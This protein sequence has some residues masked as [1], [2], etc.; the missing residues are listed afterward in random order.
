LLALMFILAFPAISTAAWIIQSSFSTKMPEPV[1]CRT[2]VF[3][4]G[5]SQGQWNYLEIQ[6]ECERDAC[7]YTLKN[8]LC[9]NLPVLCMHFWYVFFYGL[10]TGNWSSTCILHIPILWSKAT[11]LLYSTHMHAIELLNRPLHL[12]GARPFCQMFLAFG[13]YSGLFFPHKI[14]I[15]LFSVQHGLVQFSTFWPVFMFCASSWN[16]TGCHGRQLRIMPHP[17]IGFENP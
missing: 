3:W 2:Q 7:I 16:G 6:G 12:Y 14:F 5:H 11:V 8:C 9:L 13:W 4:R 15:Q 10:V 1:S 17:F